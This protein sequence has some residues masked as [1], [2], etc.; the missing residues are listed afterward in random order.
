MDVDGKKVSIATGTTGKHMLGTSALPTGQLVRSES[1]YGY[2][3]VSEF[4]TVTEGPFTIIRFRAVG[5]FG[6]SAWFE[7][8]D[9]RKQ[10]LREALAKA[11]P[12][13]GLK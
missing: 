2:P 8:T 10:E 5:E 13:R 3:E 6:S 12:R 1:F 11:Y 7:V 9:A 4:L